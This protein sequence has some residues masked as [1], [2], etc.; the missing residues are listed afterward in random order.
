[1]FLARIAYVHVRN[2]VRKSMIDLQTLQSDEWKESKEED[3][4]DGRLIE[5]Y[6]R[7]NQMRHSFGGESFSLVEAWASQ[8]RESIHNPRPRSEWGKTA[9][10]KPFKWML[11]DGLWIKNHDM[12]DDS[13]SNDSIS[14]HNSGSTI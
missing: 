1:M 7:L 8:M 4:D 9:P 13:S 3:P 14:F 5:F 2:A 6:H 12:S 10:S 11:V